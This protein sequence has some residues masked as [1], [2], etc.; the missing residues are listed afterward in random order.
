MDWLDRFVVA[1]LTL[2]TVAL[3]PGFFSVMDPRKALALCVLPL[4]SVLL[5]R[6]ISTRD[7]AAITAGGLLLVAAATA[8]TAGDQ[9]PTYMFG[10][11]GD[12]REM[13]VLA[14]LA[15]FGCWAAGRAL[16]S[17]GRTALAFAL[18]IAAGVNLLIGVVQLTFLPSSGLYSTFSGRVSGLMSNPVYFAST[19]VGVWAFWMVRGAQ[20]NSRA[21]VLITGVLAFGVSLSGSRGAIAVGLLLT[22]G[23]V[24]AVRS[25]GAVTSAIVSIVGF[26]GGLVALGLVSRTQPDRIGDVESGLSVRFRVWRAAL[27]AWADRPL[28]GWGTDPYQS[29][30]S[31]SFTQEEVRE[32]GRALLWPDP[33]NV[34]IYVLVSLGVVGVVLLGLFVALGIRGTVHWPLLAAS[35]AIVLTWMLQPVMVNGWP[36]AF[37]LFGAAVRCQSGDQG[38]GER[39]IS[40][41]AGLLSVGLG[42]VLAISFL[43]WS[44][45]LRA[46]MDSG[47]SDL[48][49]DRAGLLLPDP[50]VSQK[51]ARMHL[52][53]AV[54]GVEPARHLTRAAELA[55][56]SAR[57]GGDPRY[58]TLLMEVQI[59]QEDFAGAIR[60]GL[61]GI[62]RYPSFPL[63]YAMLGVA[64][65]AA[66][67]EET[68]ALATEQLCAFRSPSCSDPAVDG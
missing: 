17:A 39:S 42:L 13:S 14:L 35:G 36:I 12:V 62:D 65:E 33:H 51:I 57:R 10:S 54:D 49:E 52:S 47:D 68:A 44:V 66:G 34:V 61:E 48:A 4:G 58:W 46:A 25:R 22:I 19:F 56:R 31:S 32:Y 30:T 40:K 11:V 37:A 7:G 55:E 26:V 28:F 16:S 29:A 2:L 43:V 59:E 3:A 1:A 21:S 8:V 18:T 64:A 50:T 27:R 53:D 67:D 41:R 24:V 9:W 5:A 60:S 15:A 23:A 45:G 38:A 20:T 63:L 6:R